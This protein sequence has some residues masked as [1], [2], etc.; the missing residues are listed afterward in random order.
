MEWKHEDGEEGGECNPF[1]PLPSHHY[2][3]GGLAESCALI[4]VE[5][6][7]DLRLINSIRS[8]LQARSMGS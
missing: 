8:T 6:L 5:A 2:H 4:Q 7:T 3:N 1:P